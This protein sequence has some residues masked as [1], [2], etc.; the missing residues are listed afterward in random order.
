MKH[1]D[2][3]PHGGYHPGM[4]Y[5]FP[6]RER[7]T[8]PP[9][10]P[11]LTPAERALLLAAGPTYIETA[12]FGP[13]ESALSAAVEPDDWRLYYLMRELSPE[14]RARVLALT[15]LLFNLRHA[16]RWAAGEQIDTEQPQPQ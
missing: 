11:V 16:Q 2:T 7:P 15:E 9:A 8:E 12:Q 13:P 5:D 3:G 4:V 6:R 1:M 14:D 10:K